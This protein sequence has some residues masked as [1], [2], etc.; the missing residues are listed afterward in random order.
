VSL[1][2][3]STTA[4]LDNKHWGFRRLVFWCSWHVC[5]EP[6]YLLPWHVANFLYWL[7]Q[8]PCWWYS[9]L[10]HMLHCWLQSSEGFWLSFQSSYISPPEVVP[11]QPSPLLK[12][13]LW[14]SV[15][16]EILYCTVCSFPFFFVFSPLVFSVMELKQNTNLVKR[17]LAILHDKY[18]PVQHLISKFWWL[19]FDN[20][21]TIP[22]QWG[23]PLIR[24]I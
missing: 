19:S 22:L 10:F 11:S 21:N 12:A 1:W 2:T 7:N 13:V 5:K 9:V 23:Y 18:I 20:L 3:V 17:K 15:S 24:A 14:P 6:R 16:C 8:L 4:L